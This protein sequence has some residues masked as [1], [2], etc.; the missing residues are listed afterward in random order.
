MCYEPV[1]F[2]LSLGADPTSSIDE[3]SKKK[4]KYPPDKVSMGEGQDRIARQC[5]N[6]GFTN[7]SWVIL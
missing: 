5:M 3:L 1:I 4:K 2:L 6:E 7:G